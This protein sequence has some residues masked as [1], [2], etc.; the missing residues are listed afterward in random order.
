MPISRAGKQQSVGSAFSN[1]GNPFD[2]DSDT[3]A[4][5]TRPSRASSVPTKSKGGSGSAPNFENESIQEL[6]SYAVNKAEETTQK[7]DDCLRIAEMIREDA[8]NTLVTLHQ[9]GEQIHQTHQVAADMDRD[10]SRVRFPHY[11]F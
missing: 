11:P 7:V 4:P 1:K 2:S 5:N 9:Q 10:L 6:E 3:E 8:T